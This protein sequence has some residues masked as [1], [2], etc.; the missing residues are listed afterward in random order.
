[1]QMELLLH[2]WNFAAAYLW[3][4]L[5]GGR[6]RHV[7]DKRNSRILAGF[8]F[9][10]MVSIPVTLV[11]HLLHPATWFLPVVYSS[12]FLYHVIL[13]GVTE[14]WAKFLCF[15]LAVYGGGVIREPQDGAVQAAAVGLGFGTVENM[16]YIWNAP[17]ISMAV[18]PLFSTGG[19]MIYAAFWGAFYAA[20]AYSNA[21]GRDPQAY[22]IAAIS[23]F[24]VAFVHGC[25]N[26]LLSSPWPEMALLSDALILAFSVAAFF[27]LLHN[28][29][30]RRFGYLESARAVATI[31]IGLSFNPKS[32]VLNRRMGLYLMHQGAYDEAA[33][34]FS[35]AMAR[36]KSTTLLRFFK[37]VCEF[38][39]RSGRGSYP[40]LAAWASVSDR[41]KPRVR[42]ELA[43]IL[44]RD[45]KLLSA[46]KRV[47]PR[48][49]SA[50]KPTGSESAH[51]GSGTVYSQA[52]Q[53]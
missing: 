32:T 3:Y 35:A 27:Y 19:H 51:P 21:Q 33:R 22:R 6:I 9:V 2:L 38:D 11:L 40:L 13:T 52:L 23:V 41:L 7:A 42:R 31:R 28:S 29:P 10:G 1:M 16:L 49:D 5:L 47:L 15:M 53:R 24:L 18:R 17:N 14:E 8:F 20:A 39:R 43:R 25:F 50:P 37:S 44:S 12:G 46:V 4:R 26:A 36:A 45:S 30:Y 48:C 34:H